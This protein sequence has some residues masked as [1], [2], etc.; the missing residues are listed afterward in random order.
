MENRLQPAIGLGNQLSGTQ[1]AFCQMQ[2]GR[3]QLISVPS[4][5]KYGDSLKN[6]EKMQTVENTMHRHMFAQQVR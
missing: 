3:T 2:R 4:S 1:M 6:S 5:G